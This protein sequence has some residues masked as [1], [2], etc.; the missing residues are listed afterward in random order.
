MLSP[1]SRASLLIAFALSAACAGAGWRRSSTSTSGTADEWFAVPASEAIAGLAARAEEGRATAA[2]L[3]LLGSLHEMLGRPTDAVAYYAHAIE[4]GLEGGSAEDLRAA[5]AAATVLAS[6]EGRAGGWSEAVTS[7]ADGLADSPSSPRL[8]SLVH[9][10]RYRDSAR[11]GDRVSARDA[12]HAAG[13]LTDWSAVGPFGPWNLLSFDELHG[14]A[15]HGALLGTYHL[16]RGRGNAGVF[17]PESEGCN[18]ELAAPAPGWGGTTYAVTYID[19]ESAERVMFRVETLASVRL[20]ANDEEIMRR[21][22]RRN[23]LPSVHWQE[24]ALPAGRSKIV[25][26]LTSRY[27]A[28][29][30]SVSITGPRGLPIVTSSQRVSDRGYSTTRPILEESERSEASQ[31]SSTTALFE[32]RITLAE[33]NAQRAR[34]LAEGDDGTLAETPLGRTLVALSWN[35]DSSLSFDVA[36]NRSLTELERVNELEPHAWLPYLF[37]ARHHA[38]EDR[39]D[40]SLAVLQRGLEACPEQPALWMLRASLLTSY[41]LW[42]E[43]EDAIE[44]VIVLAPGS[45]EPLEANFALARSRHRTDRASE[46]ARELS[47]CNTLSQ[48]LV[49]NH[50]EAGRHA[51]AEAEVRRLMSVRGERPRLLITLAEALHARGAFRDEET[52]LE[53][54]L[55][56]DPEDRT[57]LLGLV[58]LRESR[59]DR[60]GARALLEGA[61]DGTPGDHLAERRLLALLRD[62]ELLGPFR[63]DGPQAIADYESANVSYDDPSVLVLDRTVFRI[64]PDGSL[65]ELTH[66]VSRVLTAEGIE[67]EGEFELPRGAILLRA[68]TIKAD[69]TILEPEE[70]EGKDSLS[71]PGL[72]EGDYVETEYLRGHEPPPEFP[73]GVWPW[74]FYFQGHR[75]AFHRSE[76]VVVAP[77]DRELDLSWRGEPIAVEESRSDGLRISRWVARRRNTLPREPGGPHGDEII[78]S[79]HVSSGASWEMLRQTLGE[80]LVDRSRISAELRDQ[81][82]QILTESDAA[83]PDERLD[84]LFRWVAENIEDGGDAL[85]QVS[86]MLAARTGNRTRL[87]AAMAEE[88]GLSVEIGFARSS[89]DDQTIEELPSLGMYQYVV[90]RAVGRWIHVGENARDAPSWYLSPDLL[91]QRVLLL[92][93]VRAFATIP[94]EP[95][96]ADR[97]EVRASLR[98]ASDGSAAGQIREVLTGAEAVA[99][100]AGFTRR[101][102]DERTGFYEERY[103]ADVFPGAEVSELVI[104]HLTDPDEPL[105]I[106]YH[107]AGVRLAEPNTDGL[108]LRLPHTSEL[109][110]AYAT[111]PERSTP[112]VIREPYLIEIHLEIELPEEANGEISSTEHRLASTLGRFHQTRLEPTG[113]T[114]ISLRRMLAI[115]Q[116]RIEPEEYRAFAQFC[117]GVDRVE[118]HHYEIGRR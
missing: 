44:R 108:S 8:A 53:R 111:L 83:S 66:G 12:I 104:E 59:G 10:M 11:R 16:G 46:V 84:A 38:D 97:R 30:M 75:Q 43:V 15:N 77:L 4:R 92:S 22:R 26:A 96:A 105:V 39:L 80:A 1:T 5:E 49:Q 34:E 87:L 17:V 103:V 28:P 95:R 51:E 27:A 116:G 89:W 94:E 76:L 86:H 68:R 31:L 63:A 2:E 110:A 29:G 62:E 40:D 91:G 57:A 69:G 102:A 79:L 73:G 36:Q 23:Y 64:Y 45:C 78:P 6:L 25:V 61:V 56:R 3:T 107:V 37:E 65:V 14:P 18:V 19:L 93:G 106:S 24:V 47:A 72:T 109:A 70:I 112:L 32:A 115:R 88:A 9:Q 54:I 7:L 52:I 82:Q 85:A 35:T 101:A 33:G 114:T 71:L 81:V 90:F 48:A 98:L 50:M 60:S 21:D 20:F 118:N 100:R 67:A 74:R 13:C 58:D 42:R 41:G 99:W 113:A 55:A 117:R